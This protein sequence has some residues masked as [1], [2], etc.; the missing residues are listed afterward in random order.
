V[1]WRIDIKSEEE[2]RQEVEAEMARMARIV[3]ELK[4]L[5]P[6]GVSER[7]VQKLID[8][9]VQGLSHIL[10]M[11]EE[12]LQTIEGIGEKTAAKIREAAAAAK[13]EWDA[14]DEEAARVEAERVAAEQAAVEQAA[15][16]AA[17][18]A[19]ASPAAE[20]ATPVAAEA[21]PAGAMAGEGTGEEGKP[22][23]QR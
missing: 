6:H 23:G 5:E 9:G 7:V 2:K 20:D 11:T 22:D 19:A 13:P 4:S 12:N 18:E 17:A 3:E 16:E 21:E 15:A 14:R 8:A 10:E 1:G